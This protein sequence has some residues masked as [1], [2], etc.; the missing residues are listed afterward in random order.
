MR[1]KKH[2]FNNHMDFEIDEGKED[3]R[4]MQ[5]VEHNGH[6]DLI[7]HHVDGKYCGRLNSK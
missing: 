7:Q 2:Y 3:K 6:W 5:M 1:N 4:G